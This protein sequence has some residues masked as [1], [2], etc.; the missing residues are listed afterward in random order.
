MSDHR[1]RTR[2]ERVS[3]RLVRDLGALMFASVCC[4]AGLVQHAAHAQQIWFGPQ[5]D[6]TSARGIETAPDYPELFATPSAWPEGMARTK[7]LI[8]NH[9]S[10]LMATPDE[11]R[12]RLAFLQQHNIQLAVTM[13][14]VYAVGCGAA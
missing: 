14:V 3:H 7:V 13:G 6:L 8:V 2:L 11:L 10:I 9:R 5:S 4:L 1:G 12:A